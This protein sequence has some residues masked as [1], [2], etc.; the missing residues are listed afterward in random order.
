MTAPDYSAHE[1]MHTAS[2]LMDAYGSHVGEHP[3]VEAHPDIAAKVEAAMEAMMEVYQAIGKIHL[4]V[5]D[6]D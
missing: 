5:H 3:W 1:A 4:D 2:V 6:G